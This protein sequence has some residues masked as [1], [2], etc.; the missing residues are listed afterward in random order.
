MSKG[1]RRTPTDL[2]A[3]ASQ[4][5]RKLEKVNRFGSGDSDVTGEFLEQRMPIHFGGMS[6]PFANHSIAVRSREIL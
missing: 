5:F 1:G 6:D 2:V 4:I 3:D